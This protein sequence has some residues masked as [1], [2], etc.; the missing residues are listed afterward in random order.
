MIA[1]TEVKVASQTWRKRLED[2]FTHEHHVYDY[3]A[4]IIIGTYRG[5]GGSIKEGGRTH[6]RVPGRVFSPR[7]NFG[8]GWSEMHSGAF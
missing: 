8:N 2:K 1:T 4:D 5:V 3:L 6:S 7:K